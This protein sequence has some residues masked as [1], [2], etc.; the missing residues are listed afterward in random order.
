MKK[1]AYHTMTIKTNWSEMNTID[2]Y[3]ERILEA[4]KS[5]ELTLLDLARCAARFSVIAKLFQD[6][7]ARTQDEIMVEVSD[8]TNKK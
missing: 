8:G 7:L 6:T 3:C 1:G 2:F 4:A 5:E